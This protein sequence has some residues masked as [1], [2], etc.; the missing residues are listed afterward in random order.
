MKS[1]ILIASVLIGLPAAQLIDPCIILP[2]LIPRIMEKV[3][4][5]CQ[6]KCS[7][8]MEDEAGCP[9]N[10]CTIKAV[11]KVGTKMT[12]LQHCQKYHKMA[13]ML[14]PTSSTAP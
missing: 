5:K 4:A 14:R 10:A 1:L 7:D 13:W 2:H 3:D 12:G 9:S 6:T 8:N 11:L